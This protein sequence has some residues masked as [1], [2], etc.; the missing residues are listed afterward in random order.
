MEVIYWNNKTEKFVTDLDS[1]IRA[2][3]DRTMKT[4]EELGHL[5]DMPDSKSLGKGL[6]ELRTHGK[7][8]VRLLYVYKNNRAYII[9]GFIKKAWK[10]SHGEIEYAR[11][12]QK[13]VISFA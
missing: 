6:F 1:S 7:N 4:L 2:R 11:R 12:V 5:I 8:Q 13:E 3:V 10:I 9:H